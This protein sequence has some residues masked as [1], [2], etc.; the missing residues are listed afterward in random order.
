MRVSMN[1]KQV[2]TTELKCMVAYLDSLGEVDDE[3]YQTIIRVTVG[4][5]I[6][7]LEGKTDDSI[8]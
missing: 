4:N 2:I 6:N 3:I 7:I 1:D 5:V 8:D